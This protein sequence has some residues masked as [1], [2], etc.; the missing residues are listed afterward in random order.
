[1]F[2]MI[3]GISTLLGNGQLSGGKDNSRKILMNDLENGKFYSEEGGI[4]IAL[5]K[6]IVLNNTTPVV[7]LISNLTGS[8]GECTAVTFKGRNNTRFIGE[9]TA[10]YT[11]GNNGHWIEQGKSG[12]VI[13]ETALVDRNKKMYPVN[14]QPDE[15]IAGEDNFDDYLKDK[16]M[17]AAI[18][19]LGQQ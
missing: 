2:P 15:I 7:I 1:M 5:N 8:A 16:K 9:P 14:I 4:A 12:I 3:A 6:C 17:I 11:T 19:W 10:G 13:A 18:K